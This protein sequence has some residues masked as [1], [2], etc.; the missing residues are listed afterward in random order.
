MLRMSRSRA[1]LLAAAI[2]AAGC[3]RPSEGEA[4]RAVSAA[5]VARVE[6]VRPERQTVR[7][8]VGQ[9]GHL[10]AFE[11][12]EVHARI[13]GYVKSWTV[14]IGAS[15][16][17]GEVL[18]ELS[19]PEL[20]AELRQK[21][22]SIEQAAA[23]R[24]QAEAAV[25]VARADIAGAQAKLVEVRAGI[26]R[27][28]ADDARW[29]AELHRVEQLFAAQAQ[30]GSLLDE[31]R[32]KLRSAD[33]TVEEV[34]AQVKSAEV[35]LVQATAALDRARSDVA[36]AAAA[37]DVATADAGHARSMLGYARL[38]APFDGI[39][40]QRNVDVG[41]L[42]R[43]GADGPPLF[44]VARSDVVTIAVDVPE[45]FAAEVNPGD[46]ASIKLQAMKGRV[47]EGKVSRIS[48]ALDPKAR[49]IRVEIDIPNPGAAAARPLRL[50]DDRR[51]GTHRR[52]DRPG[53]GDRR[54]EREDPLR[55]RRRRQGRA[56]AGR[57][58]PERRHAGRG[59]LG[60]GRGRSR[61]QGQCRLARRWPDRAGRRARRLN[62][63][64]CERGKGMNPG[65]LSGALPDQESRVTD[66][67]PGRDTA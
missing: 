24:K 35:G 45:A 2:L 30:T 51:R 29:R 62:H 33:A 60:R 37:I 31:T 40:I 58:G 44:V 36:A 49:T 65:G 27:A 63:D 13:A 47:V 1:G 23:K 50:R 11:T 42:T 19:V 25:E 57:A 46:R 52:A 64:R 59:R 6:V 34:K 17:K 8:V 66:L 56:P 3:D 9:P 67:D 43:P 48:W 7:R 4:G 15:V 21:E 38:E 10:Q 28:D 32:N 20:E 12:A 16:K 18:A 53:H 54:G 55:R 5:P 26:N 41:D 14:N 22:A 61:G 39:V